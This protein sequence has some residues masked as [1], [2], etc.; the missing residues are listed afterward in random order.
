MNWTKNIKLIA[1][2]AVLMCTIGMR[3]QTVEVTDH[4]KAR[5]EKML[6]EA[7]KQKASTNWM[8]YFGKQFLGQPYVGGTL[9]RAEEENLVVNLA[10][11][12][13]T[14]YI[15][16]LV[17]LTKCAQRGQT[18]FSDYCTWL[19]KVR[20]IGGEVAYTKRQHYFNAWMADNEKEGLTKTIEA[21]GKPFTG[22][23]NTTINWMSTHTS[24][25]KMLTKHPEWK[26][27][28]AALEKSISNRAFKYIPKA[29]L[30]PTA[31]NNAM[32]RKYIKDGDIIVL[33]TNKKGLD[34]VHITMAKWRK[35]G[36]HVMHASSLY[37]K[38]VDDDKSLYEYM[39]TKDSMT[40]IR[41]CRV[42]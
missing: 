25:Y 14:T 31:K 13:C 37:K 21:N 19:K 34:T 42:L 7:K 15:E 26:N 3:A 22:V 33:M 12:D 2:A 35:D 8:I 32:L 29:L 39:R 27:G 23:Q 38:V 6:G 16:A 24:S 10:E 5:I 17:A 11:V 28:I 20:Y 36:L 1:L 30:K 18:S 9:D 4:D 40:G 41:V